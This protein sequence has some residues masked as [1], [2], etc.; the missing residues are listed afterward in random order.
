M[1]TVRVAS[2]RATSVPTTARAQVRVAGIRATQTPP[3]ASSVRV[4]AIRALNDDV[5]LGVH[6]RIDDIW[7][8]IVMHVRA[9]GIWSEL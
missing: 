6:I 1:G 9:S 2:V 8:P 4:S 3:T 7:D 5:A